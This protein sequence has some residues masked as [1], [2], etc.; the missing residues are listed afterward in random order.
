MERAFTLANGVKIPAVGF[1]TW[2]LP[3][4]QGTVNAVKAALAAGYRHLDCAAL[5]GNQPQV[6][7]AVKAIGTPR[8][9]LFINS[10]LWNTDRGFD[11]ALKAFDRSL[12][13]LGLDYLDMYLIHWPATAN[14]R[15]DWCEVNLDTWRAFEKLYKEGRVRAIGVSNFWPQHLKPLMQMAEIM[16]MVNQ[17]E[18]HPGKTQA[19]VTGFCA[20]NG[21]LVEAWSP[22]GEGALMRSAELAEI[23]AKYGKSTAQAVIRWCLQNG[24]LPLPRST[25]PT[26]IKENAEV[27]DFEL[28]PEDM[29][30]IDALAYAAADS[31]LHPDEVA[32][33]FM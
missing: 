16:P 29:R 22:L 17:V 23:A 3:E 1:G 10:K 20:Q 24:V 33:N 25:S 7:A 27:F 32:E 28:R 21:I 31:G 13:E 15:E 26:H 12:N 11:N 6:G 30:R 8:G 2:D 19:D 4:G 14:Q 9:E 18:Y 5:Y